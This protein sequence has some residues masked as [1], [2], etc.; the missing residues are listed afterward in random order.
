M[1]HT[2]LTRHPREW[3]AS[4]CSSSLAFRRH[5]HRPGATCGCRRTRGR[6]RASAST[7]SAT[8]QIP[9]LDSDLAAGGA[10]EFSGAAAAIVGSVFFGGGG[11]SGLGA[12]VTT[13]VG[14][15][16]GLGERGA[17]L[18]R[19]LVIDFGREQFRIDRE[20]P[21]QV[22][23]QVGAFRKSTAHGGVEYRMLSGIAAFF[24]SNYRP[25]PG[26]RRESPLPSDTSPSCR[27]GGHRR[28]PRFVHRPEEVQ[29]AGILDRRPV[30]GCPVGSPMRG[31]SAAKAFTT[32][33]SFSGR[34]AASGLRRARWPG[35]DSAMHVIWAGRSRRRERNRR[36]QLRPAP[37]WC[38][39]DG[40]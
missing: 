28:R 1:T 17:T 8:T 7:I 12:S 5:R 18:R 19:D 6:R 15:G 27:V 9:P 30:V 29:P 14:V 34:T 39:I 2:T 11:I 36:S 21:R 40:P 10:G 33:G 23:R 32:F 16:V 22:G 25:R 13:G 24:A 4:S 38:E 3:P 31:L 35:R 37:G 20:P 26:D